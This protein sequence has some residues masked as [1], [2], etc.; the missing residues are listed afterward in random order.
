MS[1]DENLLPVLNNI[2]NSI[3][4]FN[5]PFD[6]ATDQPIQVGIDVYSLC[7]STLTLCGLLMSVLNL[8]SNCPR[9]AFIF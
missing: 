1:Q 4:V 6:I 2:E 5:N 8:I 9:V 3:P 7:S